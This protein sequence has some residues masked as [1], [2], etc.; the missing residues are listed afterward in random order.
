V[1]RHHAKGGFKTLIKP[2]REASQRPSAQLCEL[3]RTNRAARQ[4][5]LIGPR[6]PVITGGSKYYRAVVSKAVCQR[7]ENARYLRLARWARLRHPHKGRRGR[8]H[9]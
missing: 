1:S 8:A 3:I 9:K 7:L 2:S 6:N 4:E 5:N